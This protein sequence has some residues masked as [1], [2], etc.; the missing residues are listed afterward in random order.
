MSSTAIDFSG[1]IAEIEEAE[2][3]LNERRKQQE[4]ANAKR[5]AKKA[6]EQ[7][8]EENRG[9]EKAESAKPKSPRE[10][11][12]PST[13]VPIQI[14]KRLQ[15][16]A[17]TLKVVEDNADR[18]HELFYRLKALKDSRTKQELADEALELLFEKYKNVFT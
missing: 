9:V 12:R 2:R 5:G 18:F 4:A 17:I 3:A 11:K 16:T 1:S 7:N 14:S 6:A 15:R 10:P 13:T 8:E